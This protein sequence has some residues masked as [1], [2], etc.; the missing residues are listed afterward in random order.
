MAAGTASEVHACTAPSLPQTCTIPATPPPAADME[1]DDEYAPPKRQKQGILAAA[2]ALPKGGKISDILYRC[3]CAWGLFCRRVGL[4]TRVA[5]A[6]G[7]AKEGVAAALVVV[8]LSL[9]GDL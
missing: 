7:K 1:A 3:V 2:A 9:A 6:T 8:A 5:R 4:S